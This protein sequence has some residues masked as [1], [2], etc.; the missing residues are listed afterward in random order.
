MRVRVSYPYAASINAIYKH[1]F[2]VPKANIATYQKG[3]NGTLKKLHSA[4]PSKIKIIN[5]DIE[6]LKWQH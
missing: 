1:D 5:R 2:H 3:L 6:I 4:L